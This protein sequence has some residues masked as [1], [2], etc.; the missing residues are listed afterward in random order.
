V[1]NLDDQTAVQ[2][3]SKQ[4]NLDQAHIFQGNTQKP[5]AFQAVTLALDTARDVSNPFKIGFPF[6]SLF[7]SAA[8][9]AVTT[10]SIQPDSI[11]SYQSSCP[12]VYKDCI[13]L[14]APASGAY[15]T[16]LAQVGKTMTI[17][18]FVEASFR[19]GSYLTSAAGGVS[20]IDGSSITGPTQTTL[21]AATATIIAPADSLRKKTTIQNKTGAD[22]YIGGSTIAAPGT[23]NEG[24]KIPNDGIII[25]A[26]TAALYGYSAAG[27]NTS[28]NDEK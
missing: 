10:V 12:I 22:L 3:L 18:F 8:S 4:K 15:L 19:S 24:I 16:W 23:S 2:L 20:I 28:R 27:G 26:N 6:R 5:F 11:D 9:D 13:D 17:V 25:W 1:G 7:V 21:A 14:N